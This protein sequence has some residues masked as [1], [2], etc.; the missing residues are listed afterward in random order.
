MPAIRHREP[1]LASCDDLKGWEGIET[2]EATHS[3]ILAGKFH[4]QR[5]H[6]L[7]SMGLQ[8]QT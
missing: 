3:S 2:Q 5:N 8:S 1:N 4:G 6:G 7:Q